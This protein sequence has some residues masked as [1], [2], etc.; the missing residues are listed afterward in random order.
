[1]RR[2]KNLEFVGTV[3][4]KAAQARAE[5][6][7]PK[8]G[9]RRNG[10]Q[11]AAPTARRHRGV[12][13]A[14]LL[15]ALAAASV[16]AFA[17][18]AGAQMCAASN[19]APLGRRRSLPSRVRQNR[20]VAAVSSG[21]IARAP[22]TDPRRVCMTDDACQDRGRLRQLGRTRGPFEARGHSPVRQVSTL[23]RTAHAGHKG[24]RHVWRDD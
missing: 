10:G 19:S 4:A 5:D 14:L 18:A 20:L 15:A 22:G 21:G 8:A 16:D 13:L 9:L 24:A 1:M 2:A 3:R 7:G 17:P 11:R 12:M 23:S 6:A